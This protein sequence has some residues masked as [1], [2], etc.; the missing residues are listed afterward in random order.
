[1]SAFCAELHCR[2]TWSAG[3]NRQCRNRVSIR[4]HLLQSHRC[5]TESSLAKRRKLGAVADSS[6]KVL[7]L[8]TDARTSGSALDPR[9]IAYL[10]LNV[11]VVGGGG[12]EHAL[13][14]KLASSKRC[15]TLYCS[16][17]NAGIAMEEGVEVKSDLNISDHQQVLQ[18][19]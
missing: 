16:P 10:Q 7:L 2:S 19:S 8:A 17:G 18:A 3:P 13:A 5:A 9:L 4:K 12:R 6:S 1:M 11:L 15:K 14:W